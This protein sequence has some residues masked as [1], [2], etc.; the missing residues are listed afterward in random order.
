MKRALDF[1]GRITEWKREESEIGK[2]KY[3]LYEAVKTVL[4]DTD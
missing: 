2:D 1:S 3:P 4:P